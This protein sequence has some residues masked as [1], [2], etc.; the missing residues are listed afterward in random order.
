VNTSVEIAQLKHFNS[1]MLSRISHLEEEVKFLKARE[2]MLE[3]ELRFSREIN[4]AQGMSL[5]MSQKSAA[6][7]K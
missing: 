1:E 2:K 6:K 5:E 4:L 3:E 7:R